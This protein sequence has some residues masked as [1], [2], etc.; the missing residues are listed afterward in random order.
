MGC[1]SYIGNV[2]TVGYTGSRRSLLA[3]YF[4]DIVII[5]WLRCY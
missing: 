5:E 2:V 4:D 3:A 1:I